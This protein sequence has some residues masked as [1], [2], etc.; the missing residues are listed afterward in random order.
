[1]RSGPPSAVLA[2]GSYRRRVVVTSWRGTTLLAD[3]VPLEAGAVSWD[4]GQAIPDKVSLTVPAVGLGRRWVPSPGGEAADPLACYGQRLAVEMVISQAGQ[5]W[6]TRLG[7]F[8]VQEWEESDDGR[9]VSVTALGVLAVVAGDK[10]PT[11]V[12]PNPLGTFASEFR[13][14]M[15]LGVP[16]DIDGGLVDRAVPSSFQWGEDRLDALYDLV[17]AW[18]AEMAADGDGVV[19]VTPPREGVPAPVL[20]WADGEGG[21]VIALP[22][23]D[24]RAGRYNA[25]VARS[26]STDGEARDPVEAEALA[27][28]VLDPA[29]YGTERAFYGSPLIETTSAALS[30]ARTRLAAT[31]RPAYQVRV[32]LPPDP[33]PELGDAVSGTCD[34]VP[35]AGWV[36]AVSLPLVSG[37]MTVDVEVPR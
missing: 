33:R 28:G 20:E 1:M 21:V 6:R 3:D 23:S 16:V 24:T 19:R 4:A 29:L 5:E 34:G 12:S 17:D 25:V 8:R 2:S 15:S 22:R 30:A 9:S 14:L 26:A 27:T 13:R 35:H 32:T 11:A 18:P 37:A 31:T 10:F 36:S 7:W